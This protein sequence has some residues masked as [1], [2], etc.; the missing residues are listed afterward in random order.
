MEHIKHNHIYV[1]RSIFTN[2]TNYFP[3]QNIQHV[4]KVPVFTS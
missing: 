3:K 4:R 1:F 2:P